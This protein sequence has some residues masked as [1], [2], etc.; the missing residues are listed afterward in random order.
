V[1]EIAAFEDGT[2]ALCRVSYGGGMAILAG[3]SL[4]WDYSTYP[5]YYDL[6]AMFPFHTRRDEVL[7][8]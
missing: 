2:P 8:R 3:T 1:S 5:G 6:S 4:G 7:R